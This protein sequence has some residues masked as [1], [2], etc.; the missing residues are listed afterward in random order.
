MKP[1][2]NDAQVEIA[3]RLQMKL[4]KRFEQLIDDGE[5]TST[6]AAT[7]ARLLM[8]NGWSI[9]PT[10]IPQGI[11]DKITKHIDLED[12]ADLKVM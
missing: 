11:K 3:E 1:T 6:D 2:N 5:L 7:L 12:Y 4:L 9:D 10:K 8:A